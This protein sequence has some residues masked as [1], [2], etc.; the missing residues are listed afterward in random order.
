M[1]GSR[2]RWGR[3]QATG[4][5]ERTQPEH[6]T[7]RL[8]YVNIGATQWSGGGGET[9][10]RFRGALERGAIRKEDVRT[11]LRTPTIEVKGWGRVYR[12]KGTSKARPSPKGEEETSGTQRHL[13]INIESAARTDYLM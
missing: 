7:Q 12:M 3:S 13:L 9:P 2:E 11:D 1:T 10:R 8:E 5:R 4:K 6:R